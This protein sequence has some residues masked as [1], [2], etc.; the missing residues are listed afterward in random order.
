M[1]GAYLAEIEKMHA[2]MMGYLRQHASE[3]VLAEAA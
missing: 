3:I 1:S 2:E